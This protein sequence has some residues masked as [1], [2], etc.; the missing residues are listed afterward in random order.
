MGERGR[1]KEGGRAHLI[2]Q[3]LSVFREEKREKRRR[4]RTRVGRKERE[5]GGEKGGPLFRSQ[6]FFF[7]F[8]DPTFPSPRI[9]RQEK[10]ESRAPPS[11]ALFFQRPPF[12]LSILPLLPPFPHPLPLEEAGGDPTCM[13]EYTPLFPPSLSGLW[14]RGGGQTKKSRKGGQHPFFATC[15]NCANVHGGP[16]VGCTLKKKMNEYFKKNFD[17]AKM[18]HLLLRVVLDFLI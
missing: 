14:G 18:S 9:E 5:S 17:Q 11:P 13:F 7:E 6:F 15:E 10:T 8:P 4:K 3:R 1:R 2:N 16:L 12:P